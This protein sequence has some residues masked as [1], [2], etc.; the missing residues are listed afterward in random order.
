MS[1][2]EQQFRKWLRRPTVFIAN[3]WFLMAAAGQSIVGY[4]VAFLAQVFALFGAGL[5]GEA[6]VHTANAAYEIGVL[7]LPV[8]WYASAHE[9]VD[10]SMRL[11]PPRPSAMIYAA[12]AAFAGV[13]MVNNLGTWWMLLIESLGGQLYASTVPIPTTPQ[14]LTTSILLVGVIP[15]VCEELFFRGAL[16]GAWE[17]KGSKLALIITSALF[18]MLHGSILGLPTQLLMGFVLGYIVLISDSLYTGMIYHTVH[19]SVMLILAY[20]SS[21]GME[22]AAQTAALA[23]QVAAAGGFM[24]LIVQTVISAV[25]FGG[26]LYILIESQRRHGMTIEKISD[27]EADSAPMTWEELLVLL[28]GLLTVGTAYLND[29]LTITGVL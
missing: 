8:I 10:Q 25:L 14:E 12:L 1:L 20:L 23:E 26:A 6:L 4:L 16:M 22:E 27:S 2:E 29:L 13:I 28:A 11:K 7:A 24:P 21:A 5:S 3:A 17:R 9:G 19:N 18:A 15:G